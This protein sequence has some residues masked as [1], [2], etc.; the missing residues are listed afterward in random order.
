MADKE[1]PQGA[2][3]A[4]TLQGGDII[5]V[6]QPGATGGSLNRQTTVE[7]VALTPV[8][9]R[10]L[11]S[12][13]FD[14]KELVSGA[15]SVSGWYTI[16]ETDIQASQSECAIFKVGAEGSNRNSIIEFRILTNGGNF[17]KDASNTTIEIMGRGGTI[18][19][20]G[21]RLAKSDSVNTAGFKVQIE[22]NPVV[23]IVLTTQ[24]NGNIGGSTGFAGR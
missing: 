16:A 18:P 4:E 14:S 7:G 23:D 9:K 19:P 8:G 15:L 6:Y 11:T 21:V 24:L 22:I 1:W 10:T 3:P 20:T 17:V 2:D 13:R 5:G 12:G